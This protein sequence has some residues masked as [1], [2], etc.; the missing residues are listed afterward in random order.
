MNFLWALVWVTGAGSW[1]S[2]LRFDTFVRCDALRLEALQEAEAVQP[3]GG[4]PADNDTYD[5]ANM[6]CLPVK[7]EAE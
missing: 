3:H 1:D 4:L 5:I 7:P 2:G 6:R